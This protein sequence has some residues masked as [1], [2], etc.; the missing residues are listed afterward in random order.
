MHAPEINF[1]LHLAITG[2]RRGKGSRMTTAIHTAKSL[3]G[4]DH[5]KREQAN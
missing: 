1:Q 2:R 4:E 3:S 5:E